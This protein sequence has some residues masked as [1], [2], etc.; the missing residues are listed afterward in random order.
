MYW[1]KVTNKSAIKKLSTTLVKNALNTVVKS[2]M[3][4]AGAKRVD[5]ADEIGN[6]SVSAAILASG[7]LVVTWDGAGHLTLN[8]MID[9][10][11]YEPIPR[12]AEVLDMVLSM[13]KLDVVDVFLSKLPP[14]TKVAVRK[15]VPLGSNRVIN[16]RRG[17]NAIPNC[18]NHYNLCR[19]FG[20]DGECNDKEEQ[21]WMH[22]Y[23]LLS[24][25]TCKKNNMG[26]PIC[27]EAVLAT[28]A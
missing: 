1:F 26:Q 17:I 2:S 4:F 6:R 3:E 18:T 28:K 11:V 27:G 15:Q 8:T 9:S 24:C 10:E 5:Y 23:S 12:N 22:K 19:N 14:S 25:G 21:P 7:H 20:K 13:H 16:F